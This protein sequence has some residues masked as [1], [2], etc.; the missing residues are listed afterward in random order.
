MPSGQ[1]M[2]RYTGWFE[3]AKAPTRNANNE[4]VGEPRQYHGFGYKQDSSDI[5]A[6]KRSGTD[7][8]S[9]RTAGG[10]VRMTYRGGFTST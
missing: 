4:R 7:W 6:N 3:E 9:H 2:E 1:K 5:S 8:I 10:V